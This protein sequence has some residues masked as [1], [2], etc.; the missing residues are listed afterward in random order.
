MTCEWM[1]R[2]RRS[3]GPLVVMTFSIVVSSVSIAWSPMACTFA[4]HPAESRPKRSR[5]ML[6]DGS[7]PDPGPLVAAVLVLSRHSPRL[8]ECSC[9]S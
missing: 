2:Q 5:S 3:L 7:I 4:H 1:I 9:G 8:P 6:P